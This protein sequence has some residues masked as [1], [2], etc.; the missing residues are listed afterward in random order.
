MAA[1]RQEA[2]PR[3]RDLEG[4]RAMGGAYDIRHNT[5][6]EQREDLNSDL[7]GIFWGQGIFSGPG[8]F[9]GH[10]KYGS[11]DEVLNNSRTNG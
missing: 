8:I 6:R 4:V 1:A 11:Y 9:R 10:V 7:K 2:K 3:R 5:N